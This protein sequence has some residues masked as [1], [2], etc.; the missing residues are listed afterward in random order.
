MDVIGKILKLISSAFYFL[1]VANG[2]FKITY[3]VHIIFQLDST[4]LEQGSA[5]SSQRRKYGLRFI[6]VQTQ[7]K[8]GFF[9]FF[10][11]FLAT[12]MV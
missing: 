2:N 4:N 9:L 8:N 11:F 12:P 3:I 6:S 10:F 1:N 7:A 5:S